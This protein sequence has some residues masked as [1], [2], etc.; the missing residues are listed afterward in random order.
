MFHWYATRPVWKTITSPPGNSGSE[1]A[2]VSENF[3]TSITSRSIHDARRKTV[4]NRID[5]RL[6]CKSAYLPPCV[7]FRSR[8]PVDLLRGLLTRSW[9][10]SGTNWTRVPWTNGDRLHVRSSTVTGARTRTTLVTNPER[11]TRACRVLHSVFISIFF[12]ICSKDRS[13]PRRPDSGRWT[14]S[15]EF[16][17]Y[18]TGSVRAEASRLRIAS[19]SVYRRWRNVFQKINFPPPTPWRDRRRLYNRVVLPPDVGRSVGRSLRV[20]RDARRNGPKQTQSACS[21]ALYFM[22]QRE[23]GLMIFLFLRP[24]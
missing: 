6:R 1:R 2:R 18:S 16:V 7:V 3:K 12:Y 22:D 11:S 15:G 23:S 24:P 8:Q 5:N 19:F 21:Y 4:G 10:L 9:N 17:V 20:P 14:S 13:A